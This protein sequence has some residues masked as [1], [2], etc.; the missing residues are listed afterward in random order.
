MDKPFHTQPLHTFL[1]ALASDEPAPGGGAAAAT[2]VAMSAALAGMA[3]RFATRHLESADDLAAQADG[4][5]ERAIP[6]A[7][8]DGDAYATVLAAYRLPR[9]DRERGDRIRA[10][11]LD[12]SDVPLTVAALGCE[13]AELALQLVESG[14]R[15]LVGDALAAV[16]LAS[17][18]AR[19][20]ATLARLNLVSVDDDEGR[21]RR[22]ERLLES[23]SALAARADPAS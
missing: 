15:N 2:T 20:A 9:D 10:A 11:L 18:A 1:T 23:A 14:N 7:Q 17:A 12:A 8:A 5:R 13:V 6:L 3:A 16:W 22:A 21:Q 4:L 19:A